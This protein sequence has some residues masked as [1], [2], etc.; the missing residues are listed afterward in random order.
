MELSRA[1]ERN[2][3]FTLGKIS[4]VVQSLQDVGAADNVG[5]YQSGNNQLERYL[6]RAEADELGLVLDYG[7]SLWTLGFALCEGTTG[8]IQLVGE[9][10]IFFEE[11]T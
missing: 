3:N 5:V 11:L 10:T 8:T 7:E 6:T 2:T 9:T 1:S 4:Q